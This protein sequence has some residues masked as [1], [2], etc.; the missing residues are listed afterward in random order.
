MAN[1]LTYASIY[2]GAERVSALLDEGYDVNA[3]DEN[4]KAALLHAFTS[5]RWD[6]NKV[7]EILIKRGADVT[8]KRSWCSQIW[9]RTCHVQPGGT[10]G[11]QQ[12]TKKTE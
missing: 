12:G 4:G 10:V 11:S 3:K 7:I 5:R 8:I 9:T 6:R 2:E 1:A